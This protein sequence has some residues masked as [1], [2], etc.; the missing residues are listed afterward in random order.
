MNNIDGL[1]T[2]LD[3]E[4]TKQLLGLEGRMKGLYVPY[5]DIL[6]M[7]PEEQENY[8]IEMQLATISNSVDL[9][10]D[11]IQYAININNNVDSIAGGL[12]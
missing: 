1:K 4:L 6:S 2:Y 11:D 10:H 8:F 9:L 12:S 7:S 3:L 5:D